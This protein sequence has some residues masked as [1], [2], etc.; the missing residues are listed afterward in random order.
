M[1]L[2]PIFL[3]TLVSLGVCTSSSSLGQDVII[4]ERGAKVSRAD[5]RRDETSKEP[6]IEIEALNISGGSISLSKRNPVLPP[7][8]ISSIISINGSYVLS[9]DMRK[10]GRGVVVQLLNV[11]YPYRTRLTISEQILEF[12]LRQPGYWKI[13]IGISQ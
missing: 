2:P 1:R 3:Y 9:R 13:L 4:Y 10:S 6:I 7:A 11:V 8:E 5:I 12:E